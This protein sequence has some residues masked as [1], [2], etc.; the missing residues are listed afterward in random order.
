MVSLVRLTVATSASFLIIAL[1]SFIEHFGAGMQ[2]LIAI[3]GIAVSALIASLVARSMLASAVSVAVGG[4]F[5]LLLTLLSPYI[6]YIELK[7]WNP[8]GA[9]GILE[10]FGRILLVGIAVGISVGISGMLRVFEAQKKEGVKPPAEEV[11]EVKEEKPETTPTPPTA[12][13]AAVQE[14]VGVPTETITCPGCKE[15]IPSDA[16]FCPLCGKRVKES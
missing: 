1:F 11:V 3:F 12:R 4:A 7:L 5:A 10:A 2:E 9:F 15:S 8:L 6:F 14:A 16:I 13:E